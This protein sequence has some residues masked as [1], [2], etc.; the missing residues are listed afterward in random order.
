MDDVALAMLAQF[1]RHCDPPLHYSTMPF[2]LVLCVVELFDCVP[3]STFCLQRAKHLDMNLSEH[4]P[5][6]GNY[7]DGRWAWLTRD[8]SVLSQPIPVTGRQGLFNL[9]PEVEH[10]VG[11]QL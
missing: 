3:T 4:E 10:Q 6:L 8:L 5:L 9:S 11:E 2:G 7:S 1:G